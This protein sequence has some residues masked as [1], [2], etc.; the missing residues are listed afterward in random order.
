MDHKK[1]FYKQ[2]REDFYPLLREQGFKGSGQHFRRIN[3][4]V[5]HTINI[6][7]NKYGGSCCINLGLHLSFLPIA[8]PKDQMP[9]LSTIKE[10]D[11]VFRM[12]L[13][14]KGKSDYWWKF[15]SGVIYP[16]VEKR[17]QHLIKTYQEEGETKFAQFDTV[18]KVANMIS[19][20]QIEKANYLE[21][22]GGCVPAHGAMIMAKINKHLGNIELSKSL[23]EAGLKVLDGAEVLRNELE[24]FLKN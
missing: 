3:G 20:E 11:C 17:V 21:I 13:A 22:F 23:A 24:G 15:K 16:S 12:R 9:D 5:I 14:P 1:A 8:W 10:I 4:D 7:N 18:E 2:L 6:Q 19:V